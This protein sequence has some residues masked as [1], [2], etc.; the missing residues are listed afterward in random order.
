[1]AKKDH[2]H[3]DGK[4]GRSNATH[5][6]LFSF[7]FYDLKSMPIKFGNHIFITLLK[8]QGHLSYIMPSWKINISLLFRPFASGVVLGLFNLLTKAVSAWSIG[9]QKCADAA[10]LRVNHAT[11]LLR[12]TTFNI[13]FYSLAH[14]R[15]IVIGF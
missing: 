4:V 9:F 15:V 10:Q 8:W 6:K 1:M 13:F 3:E 2:F 7:D 5:V 11:K 12:R 14:L